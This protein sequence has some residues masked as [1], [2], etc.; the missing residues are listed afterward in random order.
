[1]AAQPK[2]PAPLEK[3]ECT[4]GGGFLTTEPCGDEYRPSQP[5]YQ[6]LIGDR[7][8]AEGS[9]RGASIGSDPD[10]ENHLFDIYFTQGTSCLVPPWMINPPSWISF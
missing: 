7:W 8:E 3:Y 10:I 9:T 4:H 6:K 2:L 5:D 1:M